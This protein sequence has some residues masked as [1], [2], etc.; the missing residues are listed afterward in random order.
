MG[1]PPTSAGHI[2]ET[3]SGPATMLDGI[4]FTLTQHLRIGYIISLVL[5]RVNGSF[6]SG[7]SDSGLSA[8]S[9]ARKGRKQCLLHSLLGECLSFTVC[10][11]GLMKVTCL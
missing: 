10:E 1:Q 5:Q 11:V 7:L 3:Q 2:L 4:R 6:S 8:C 9:A